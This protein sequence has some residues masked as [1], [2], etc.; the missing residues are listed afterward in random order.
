MKEKRDK[1]VTEKK[2]IQN[3][4]KSSSVAKFRKQTDLYPH[5]HLCASTLGSRGVTNHDLLWYNP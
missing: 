4:G 2:S 3:K 1:I 5:N